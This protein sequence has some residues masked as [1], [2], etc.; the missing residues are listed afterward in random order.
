MEQSLIQNRNAVRFMPENIEEVPEE[1]KGLVDKN[2]LV[3][4]FPGN[5]LCAPNFWLHIYIC[6]FWGISSSENEKN[7]CEESAN[8]P[9]QRLLLRYQGVEFRKGGYPV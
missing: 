2:D 7:I 8:V 4:K 9:K 6:K 1:V 5:G 3:Y